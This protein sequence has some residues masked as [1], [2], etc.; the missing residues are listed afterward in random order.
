MVADSQLEKGV[1]ISLYYFDSR[2]GKIDPGI[3]G[4]LNYIPLFAKLNQNLF[5]IS[6]QYYFVK[7]Y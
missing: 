6:F 1:G 5:L 7:I 3:G 4:S 2:G